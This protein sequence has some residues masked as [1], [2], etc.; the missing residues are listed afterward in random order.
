VRVFD[1]DPARKLVRVFDQPEK[2][3]IMEDG[4]VVEVTHLDEEQGDR[5]EMTGLVEETRE[6]TED[7]VPV[8]DIEDRRGSEDT[9]DEPD[10]ETGNSQEDEKKEDEKGEAGGNTD[11]A[12][13]TEDVKIGEN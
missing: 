10:L 3:F 1:P 12:G 11:V 2:T 8:E 4:R 7:D 6:A 13:E 5:S 9:D